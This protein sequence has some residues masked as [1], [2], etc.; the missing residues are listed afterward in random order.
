MLKL[1]VVDAA[2]RLC[3]VW[4]FRPHISCFALLM[5]F[6]APLTLNWVPLLEI[7]LLLL[8]SLSSYT[9]DMLLCFVVFLKPNHFH[10]PKVA[11]FFFVCFWSKPVLP[12]WMVQLFFKI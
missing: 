9:A 12:D 5:G 6:L 3:T 2:M 4:L 11:P 8:P 1:L 7:S 10:T